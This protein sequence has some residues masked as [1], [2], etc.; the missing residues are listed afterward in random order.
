MQPLNRKGLPELHGEAN[1]PPASLSKYC[2]LMRP[3]HKIKTKSKSMTP[4][5][6]DFSLDAGCETR[7]K[8]TTSRLRVFVHGIT[9]EPWY[10]IARVTKSFKLFWQSLA[11]CHQETVGTDFFIYGLCS[12]SR[13]NGFAELPR[14]HLA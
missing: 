12:E 9:S 14:V 8:S 13:G 4:P 1:A 3:T 5:K 2:S 11:F 10:R 7:R 6:W